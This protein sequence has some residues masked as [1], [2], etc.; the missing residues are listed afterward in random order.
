MTD[1]ATA[2]PTRPT[3]K[4]RKD[5]QPPT[6][7][8]DTLELEFDLAEEH[9]R[10]RSKMTLRENPARSDAG[11]ELVLDGEALELVSVTVDGEKISDDRYQVGE[12]TLT[13]TG[14]PA[15]CVLE[16]EVVIEPQENTCF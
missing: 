8:V 1:T 7:L 6:H 16:I 10:V 2:T 12:E 9:T 13:L 14:L 3:T 11:G 4:Y 15:E 5:Y